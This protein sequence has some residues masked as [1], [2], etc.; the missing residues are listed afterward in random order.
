MKMLSLDANAVLDLCYRFYGNEVFEALWENLLS[1]ISASQI[2]FYITS[3]I[4]QEILSYI[5]LH[6]LDVSIFEVFIK[7]Y[8]IIFPE[9]D[10]FGSKTLELKETLL[11]FSAARKSPHVTRDNYG[12]S[13]IV[14]FAK[15]L[16][17][18]AVV[19]TSETRSKILNWENP[20]HQRHIKVPNLCELFNVECMNWFMLFNYLGHK[21]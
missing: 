1:C 3:S 19:L 13:D 7:E 5:E 21:Y 8:K 10:E 2:R 6:E 11:G 18:D 16:G 14:S 4:Y 12:D 9:S 20:D 17:N 15:F